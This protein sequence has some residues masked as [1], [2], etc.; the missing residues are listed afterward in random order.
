MTVPTNFKAATASA[1]FTTARWIEIEGLPVAYGTFAQAAGFFAA[2]S[3]IQKFDSIKPYMTEIP[4]MV[5]SSVDTLQGGAL[6]AAQ[7]S[8]TILDYDGT[9]TALC[10]AGQLTGAMRLTSDITAAATVIFFTGSSSAFAAGGLCYIGTETIK[11]GAIDVPN[12]KFTGCTRGMYRST[13]TAFA[14][15]TP[16]GVTP[17]VMACRRVWYNQVAVAGD[18]S[19]VAY[20]LGT[21]TFLSSAEPDKCVRFGGML[22]DMVLSNDR[23][24]FVLTV[25]S[26]DKEINQNFLNTLRQFISYG[27]F[28][29]GSA[30][31][32]VGIT[33]PGWPNYDPLHNSLNI[34]DNSRGQFTLNELIVFR[35]DDEVFVGKVQ[36]D[37]TNPNWTIWSILV[38]AR[39]QFSTAPTSHASGAIAQ[40][41]CAVVA[42]SGA[43]FGT[44]DV[45]VASKFQGGVPNG[46]R[47]DH[48]LAILLQFLM[49]RTGDASNGQ[50]DVLPSGWGLGVSQARIDIAGIEKVMLEDAQLRFGGTLQTSQSFPDF[51]RNILA[52]CGCYY[53]ITLGDLF[54]IKK[55]RPNKPDVATRTI[56]DSIR[57]RNAGTKWE[58]NWSGAVAEIVFNFGWDIVHN[59]YKRVDVFELGEATVYV[60]DLARTVEFQTTLLYPGATGIPGEPDFKPFDIDTWLLQRKDFYRTRYAKP[61]PIFRERL[62]FSSIDIEIGDLCAVTATNIPNV[63][64]GTRGVTAAVCEVI[65]KTIDDGAGCIDFVLLHTGW[66]TSQYRFISPSWLADNTSS[67]LGS[68]NADFSNAG[69][70]YFTDGLSGD[71]DDTGIDSNGASFKYW[72]VGFKVFV[73]SP[74]L[75]HAQLATITSI[76]GAGG[77]A[78]LDIFAHAN[79]GTWDVA[80]QIG[81]AN[82][83]TY[84]DYANCTAGQKALYASL[85][86]T[87]D[88]LGGADNAHRWFPT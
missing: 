54:T 17:Y 77:G 67:D 58:A 44:P 74:D 39:A 57:I 3:T 23:T 76:T 78:G 80:T 68:G 53:I 16:I 22:T 88:Q 29:D 18:G 41:V 36:S 1:G 51:M 42:H 8:F 15:G 33:A 81:T 30:T 60:K 73:W 40:E 85:A 26:L 34:P 59:K 55:L 21:P 13:P 43:T 75:S 9:L 32:S 25:T 82:Y 14:L 49:S 35:L 86:D 84:P 65:G 70:I 19:S 20:G 28:N 52:T 10:G 61:P 11:I 38:T 56:D 72:Q 2:R 62:N 37:T 64:T 71:N 24:G 5:S 46:V 50:Y 79:S 48:P 27:G 87:N 6:N 47:T 31:A 69:G 12:K 7:V 4:K 63:A 66:L 45:A 83:I